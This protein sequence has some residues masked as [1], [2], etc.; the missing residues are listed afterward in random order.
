MDK[1]KNGLNIF[2]R[3]SLFV[4]FIIIFI[5]NIVNIKI[6]ISEKEVVFNSF[7]IAFITIYLLIIIINILLLNSRIN[8]NKKI[9]LMV[10]LGAILRFIWMAKIN[11]PLSSDYATIYNSAKGI[12]VGD[13]S[14]IYGFGYFARFT[15]LF[16]TVI[17]FNILLRIFPVLNLTIYKVIKFVLSIISMFLV[18][19][20]SKK[21]FKNEKIQLI[22]LSIVAIFPAFISYVSTYCTENL[23]IW[24]YLLAIWLF[25]LNN[26]ENKKILYIVI[27]FILSIANLFRTVGIIFLIGIMVYTFIYDKKE[28][29]EKIVNIILIILPYLLFTVLFSNILITLKLIDRPLYNPIEPKTTSILKGLNADSYGMWNKEDAEFIEENLKNIDFKEQCNNR[30]IERIK[31]TP[32]NKFAKLFIMKIV[33]MWKTGDNGGIYWA[34]LDTEYKLSCISIFYNLIN[35]IFTTLC[36]IGFLKKEQN[37][38]INL[39]YI[40]FGGYSLVFFILEVQPRYTYIISYLIIF[41]ALSGIEKTIEIFENRK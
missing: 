18:Y 4:F 16:P 26:D 8:K 14:D 12:L 6:E 9:F 31:N 11:T 34:G 39:F 41:F 22:S 5:S 3:I 33:I 37:I 23:A 27:G 36:I 35:M 17:Y 2:M 7:N 40:L 25:L 15:H 28:N 32:I 20:I 29:K 10:I 38:Y 30:I 24:L 21:I 19:L 1:K 13:F